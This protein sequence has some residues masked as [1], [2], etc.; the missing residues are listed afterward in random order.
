MMRVP[1]VGTVKSPCH[2]YALL[3]KKGL[4]N[5]RPMRPETLTV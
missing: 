2:G 4:G 5:I 1:E 3:R